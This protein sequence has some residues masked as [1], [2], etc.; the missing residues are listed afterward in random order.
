MADSKDMARPRLPALGLGYVQSHRPHVLHGVGLAT[1]SDVL[2][3]VTFEAARGFV[4]PL[5][6][7]R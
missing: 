6:S 5:G 1:W 3:L 2:D 4:A 7:L